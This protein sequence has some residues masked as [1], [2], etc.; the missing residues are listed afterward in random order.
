MDLYLNCET[1]LRLWVEYGAASFESR[2]RAVRTDLHAVGAKARRFEAVIKAMQ[3]HEAEA[4]LR[5]RP[6]ASVLKSGM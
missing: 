3:A 6:N 5:A 4:H 1:C 2:T